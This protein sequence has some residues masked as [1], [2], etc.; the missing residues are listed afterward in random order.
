VGRALLRRRP[1]MLYGVY[2]CMGAG[3]ALIGASL[4]MQVGSVSGG[5]HLLTVGALGLSMLSAMSIAARA[6][7]GL[8]ADPRPW[9]AQA[10]LA[11]LLAASARAAA[12][13]HPQAAPALWSVSGLAW[14]GAFGLWAWALS[15][16]LLAPR[17]DGHGGCH[18]TD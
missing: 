8:A 9:V 11:L 18:G 14:C 1:L 6:H 12:A 2:A 15:A 13:W 4:V 7:C 5:R 10:A 16:T 3:Y 17:S